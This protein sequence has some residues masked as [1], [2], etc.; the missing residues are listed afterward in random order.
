MV[1]SSILKAFNTRPNSAP[2]QFN[3]GVDDD[4]FF[5]TARATVESAFRRI[6][7]SQSLKTQYRMAWPEGSLYLIP[8]VP[9]TFFVTFPFMAARGTRS[10]DLWSMADKTAP[11]PS[12]DA[13]HSL[14]R[15]ILLAG[16][17]PDL[18]LVSSL[19]AAHLASTPEATS[20]SCAIEDGDRP[21]AAWYDARYPAELARRG[22]QRL[23]PHH[24]VPCRQSHGHFAHQF[25]RWAEYDHL[26]LL[27]DLDAHS[28]T[29]PLCAPFCT[30]I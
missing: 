6:F 14:A 7:W 28:N 12:G 16:M 11:T 18:S 21:A 25:L 27:V 10:C 4:S 19:E 26:V 22:L 23:D 20:R 24:G 5:E 17:R 8:H 3:V 15:R 30:S 13:G 1:N 2:T 9:A 29:S